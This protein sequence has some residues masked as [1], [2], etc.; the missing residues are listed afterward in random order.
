MPIT[1]PLFIDWP[2]PKSFL[3]CIDADFGYSNFANLVKNGDDEFEVGAVITVNNYLGILR[4]GFERLEFQRQ[5]GERD[6]LLVV[7]DV[8]F[9]GNAQSNRL[10]QLL[11]AVKG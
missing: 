8:A 1:N 10:V 2:F 7:K 5:L 11:L 9:F 4:T 3:V 6:F